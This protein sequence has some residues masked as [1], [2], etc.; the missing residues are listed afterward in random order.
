[1]GIRAKI[2]CFVGLLVL[3]A[4]VQMGASW[5]MSRSM[6]IKLGRGAVET[7]DS[8]GRSIRKN[9]SDRVGATL[10]AKTADLQTIVAEVERATL[11]AADFA[12]TAMATARVSPE[13]R[14]L[15]EREIERFFTVTL[16]ERMPSV[17]GIGFTFDVGGFSPIGSKHYFPYAYRE[18][19]GVVFSAEIVIP[20]GVDPASL[21]D[22]DRDALVKDETGAEYYAAAVPPGHNPAT[23]LPQTVSWTKPYIDETTHYPMLSAVTPLFYDGRVAGVALVDLAL[24]DLD[25]LARDLKESLTPGAQTLV[26]DLRGGAVL[27]APDSP[28]M[29][30][31]S[32]LVDRIHETAR[33]VRPAG[34][35]H[36]DWTGDGSAST[37]FVGNVHNLFGVAVLVPDDELYADTNLALARAAALDNEQQGE[38]ARIRWV[39]L[40]SLC[41]MLCVSAL[42]GAIVFSLTRRL[43]VIVAKLNHDAGGVSHASHNINELASCLAD[44]TASQAAALEATAASLDEISSK[45]RANADASET[46]DRTMK[47]ASLHVDAGARQMAGMTE[48]M[49][50]IS[51]SAE[52]IGAIIKTI[53]SISFQTNLLALNAAVEASRAGEAGKG[54]AVVADEVRNLAGRSAPAA[55]ETAALID[56]SAARGG[57]VRESVTSMETAFADIRSGVAEAAAWVDRIRLS[58]A[59]QAEAVAAINQSVA[60][61]DTAVKRNEQAA[62]EAAAT[63]SELADQASSLADTA[64]N[65]SRLANGR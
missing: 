64:G 61:L 45:I 9:E 54:F 29:T 17:S 34:V 8:M 46:C 4:L 35:V 18:D 2:L 36:N 25:R 3:V 32:P 52:K 26:F 5:W 16:K 63:S 58:T 15:A 56:E 7:V 47:K 24:T 12:Y 13:G 43:G 65:L 53:E 27:S 48:A 59:E 55:R 11:M 51:E 44:E 10:L 31:G 21:S 41:V 39:G 38:M 20:D 62:G 19:G 49:E 60:N 37:L 22:A 33:E 57:A 40:I 6:G 14:D 30:D 28:D 1:M 42:V 50:G 23:P